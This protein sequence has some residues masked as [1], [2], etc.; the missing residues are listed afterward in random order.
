MYILQ[1]CH[2]FYGGIRVTN[3]FQFH[4]TCMRV[5]TAFYNTFSV[6]IH[7]FTVFKQVVEITATVK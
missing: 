4:L 2:D 6:F 1:S 3:E 7:I 5:E